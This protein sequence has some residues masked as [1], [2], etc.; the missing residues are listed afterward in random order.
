MAIDG[1]TQ[2][3]LTLTVDTINIVLQALGSQQY[4]KVSQTI[5]QIRS[6]ATNQLLALSEPPVQPEP[7]VVE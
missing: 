1:T 2:I 3:T 4:D 6:Q 7:P 5:D